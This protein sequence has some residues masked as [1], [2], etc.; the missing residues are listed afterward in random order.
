MF[1]IFANSIMTATRSR[2]DEQLPDRYFDPLGLTTSPTR[3]ADRR[4]RLLT[5]GRR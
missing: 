4:R 1:D 5:Q 2:T 3:N